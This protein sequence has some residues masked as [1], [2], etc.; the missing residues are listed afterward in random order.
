[1]PVNKMWLSIPIACIMLILIVLAWPKSQNDMVIE[2]DIRQNL[3]LNSEEEPIVESQTIFIDIKGEVIDPG[4][5]EM[6]E[7]DRVIDAITL[8][9]GFKGD[10]DQNSVN[11]AQLLRDE[12]VIFV[13]KIGEKT[14]EP[15][16]LVDDGKVRINTATKDELVTIPGIGEQKATRIIEYREAHGPFSQNEDL[17]NISGI[18]EKTLENIA[19]Y[20]IVP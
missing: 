6:T 11:L 12:M 14:I 17:L 16:S 9:G 20:I 13:P 5:Y 3:A 8:A 19:E 15:S 10:A 4:V 1:M 18:G 7:G 2:E